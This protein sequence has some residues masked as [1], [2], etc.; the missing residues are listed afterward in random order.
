MRIIDSYGFTKT[1]TNI[2][3]TSANNPFVGQIAGTRL[4]VGYTDPY[5]YAAT[6][7]TFGVRKGADPDALVVRARNL[8][9]YSG[10]TYTATVETVLENAE[11]GLQATKTML[12]FGFRATF[13]AYVGSTNLQASGGLRLSDSNI[14][15]AIVLGTDWAAPAVLGSSHYFEITV[16]RETGEVTV[17]RDNAYLKTMSISSRLT[18]GVSVVAFWIGVRSSQAGGYAEQYREDAFKDVILSEIAAN[19]PI[20]KVGPVSL[21]HLPVKTVNATTWTANVA[22]KTVVESLND[23][24]LAFGVADANPTSVNVT[25]TDAQGVL[26][27]DTSSIGSQDVLKA[28][29]VQVDAQGASGTSNLR[30]DLL[31]NGV[32]EQNQTA[33]FQQSFDILRTPLTTTGFAR[34]MAYK[35]MASTPAKAELDKYTVKLAATS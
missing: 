30:M 3:N 33:A 20:K 22:G 21:K 25:D 31:K 26:T 16:D 24:Q 10:S 32:S 28:I 12:S 18:A 6:G 27:F 9:N 7:P 23:T 29:M 34:R 15:L 14:P 8:S 4:T 11:A 35:T 5:G 2:F 1:P 13:A 17:Y 19:D